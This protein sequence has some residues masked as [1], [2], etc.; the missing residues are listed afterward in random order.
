LQIEVHVASLCMRPLIN[1]QDRV[2]M[3]VY[4]TAL[5]NSSLYRHV[6]SGEWVLLARGDG[7]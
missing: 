1:E 3:V 4:E 2:L 5:T 7:D 6:F